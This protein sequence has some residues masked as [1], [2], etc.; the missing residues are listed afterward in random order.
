V[1]PDAITMA[2]GLAS[3]F[4]IA[5]VTV[6]DFLAEGITVGDLG[7]T[8][9][10]GPLACAAALATLDVIER[11]DLAGNA[12]RVGLQLREGALA[13]GIPSVQGHGLL[14]GLRLG[15]PAQPVQRALFERRIL[16]GTSADP[17]SCDASSALIL[18]E[19]SGLAPGRAR[20]GAVMIVVEG[21]AGS[22]AVDDSGAGEPACLLVHSLVGGCHSGR[23][24][25]R[26]SGRATA[27]LHSTSAGTAPRRRQPRQVRVE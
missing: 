11:E 10:G 18:A 12:A 22:L 9:G 14:L 15:R 26:S 5:S 19:R 6:G 13:L 8:F 27:P 20:R 2:K 21:S 7:S 4:P 17:R 24:R 23:R 3:G 25:S 16:T 1:T